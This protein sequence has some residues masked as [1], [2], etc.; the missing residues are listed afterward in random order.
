MAKRPRID[1]IISACLIF[2]SAQALTLFISFRVKEFVE[3]E[4]ITSPRLSAGLP[5]A[6]FFG[7]VVLMGLVLFLIPVSK[8][9]IVLKIMFGTLF[10][11]GT[12]VVLALVTPVLISALAAI[13]AGFVWLFRPRVWLHNV[14]MVL[15]LVSAA[16]VFGFMLA[17]W[18]AMVAMLVISVYDVVAVRFG[19]MLWM[20]NRLSQT[21][22]LPVFLIPRGI[23][24]WNLSLRGGFR[25]VF[26]G[27]A[28]EREFSILGGGDIGLPLLLVVSVFF[29]YG[30]AG[31]MMVGAFA[32]IGLICAYLIQLLF[33]KGKPMPA[34][35]PISV[36]SLIG[37]LIVQSSR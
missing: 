24:A 18:A 37:F 16:S 4:G 10:T 17:P 2:I 11:W 28:G 22:S 26:E 23:A 32:V 19:Y 8:L 27:E 13:M 21:D 1:P 7:V 3:A 29:G 35:P 36:L 31:S 12:F 30:L 33:L 9:R 6:Y 14:L 15:A 20:A 34:M 5:I 25:K